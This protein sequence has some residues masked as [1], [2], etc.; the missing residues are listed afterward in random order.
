MSNDKLGRFVIRLFYKSD[1]SNWFWANKLKPFLFLYI[2]WKN[3]ALRNGLGA[4]S[5]C[6]SQ[7]IQSAWLMIQY[8]VNVQNLILISLICLSG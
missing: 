4:S 1:S 3:E 7:M 5:A 2:F 6:N 8:R